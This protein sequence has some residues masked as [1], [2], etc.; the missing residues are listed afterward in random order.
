MYIGLVHYK[1]LDF[2]TRFFSPEI[3][4]QSAWLVWDLPTALK[5]KLRVWS[6]L[7]PRLDYRINSCLFLFFLTLNNPFSKFGPIHYPKFVQISFEPTVLVRISGMEDNWM[8]EWMNIYFF[9]FLTDELS[10]ILSVCHS[11]RLKCF[12]F[13]HFP[14]SAPW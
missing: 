6:R 2:I 12:I 9:T 14:T 1:T 7:T 4:L 10:H 13:V 8:N 5:H 3:H 11:S